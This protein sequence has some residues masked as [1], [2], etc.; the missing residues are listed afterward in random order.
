MIAFRRGPTRATQLLGRVKAHLQG[1]REKTHTDFIGCGCG[2]NGDSPKVGEANQC[3]A[4]ILRHN[5]GSQ[6]FAKS[7]NLADNWTVAVVF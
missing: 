7:L 3:A 4:F 2:A 5:C 1:S 6:T